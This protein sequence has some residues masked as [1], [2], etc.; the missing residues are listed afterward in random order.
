MA[1]ATTAAATTAAVTTAAVTTAAATTAVVTTEVAIAVAAVMVLATATASQLAEN[2][3]FG[4]ASPPASPQVWLGLLLQIGLALRG[5]RRTG[6]AHGAE[7]R[8]GRV[9]TDS[10][11]AAI[12][13]MAVPVRLASLVLRAALA[14]VVAVGVAVAPAAAATVSISAENRR[15]VAAWPREALRVHRR[16]GRALLEQPHT[17]GQHQRRR[18]QRR[19]HQ[20]RRL[21]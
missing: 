12:Q 17:G 10:L 3:H 14:A 16:P 2:R 21:Q 7:F 19:R 9:S 20:C 13:P 6:G 5:Q 1:A 4:V 15:S 11:L 18:H 8:L